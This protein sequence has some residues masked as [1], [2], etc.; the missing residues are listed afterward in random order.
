MLVSRLKSCN[1]DE[2]I[3]NPSL[4]LTYLPI[5]DPDNETTVFDDVY[6]LINEGLLAKSYKFRL[7]FFL[8]IFLSSTKVPAYVIASYIKRLSR[9]ALKSKPRTLLAILRLVGNLL[10]RH[11][12]LLALRD[13]VD[14]KAR[15]MELDGQYC[16]L[17]SW[18]EDDPFN[19]E[20]RDLR[21]TNAM[22]S[23][24]W[25]LMPL[26][27]HWHPRIQKAAAYLAEQ[28]LPEMEFDLSEL[29]R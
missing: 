10:M 22:E 23:C 9:L 12:I 13:R 26:R 28:K 1:V 25:E 24:L 2:I 15:N 4:M 21:N 27:Y 19:V 6:S 8:N 17:R 3:K 29:L 16:T 11:P 5:T 18:L 20:T 14:D 7:F